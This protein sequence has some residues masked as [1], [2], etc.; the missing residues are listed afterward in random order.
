MEPETAGAHPVMPT[1][2]SG[3]AATT[4]EIGVMIIMS[5]SATRN[6]STSRKSRTIALNSGVRTT[7]VAGE[8]LSEHFN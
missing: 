6:G 3:E 5:T 7:A 4:P 2:I 8:L 1:T